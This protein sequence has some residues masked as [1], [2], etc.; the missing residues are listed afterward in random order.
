MKK[1]LLAMV[2]GMMIMS[3]VGLV[4]FTVINKNHEAELEKVK[5]EYEAEV[6]YLEE[7]YE[8]LSSEYIELNDLKSEL[9]EQVYR[10]M[11]GENYEFEI[12]YDDKRRT[13]KKTGKG[14]FRDVSHIIT[15]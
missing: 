15:W 3:C 14:L 11:E 12:K 1:N 7:E 6:N 2:I 4:G 9:E 10:M 5:A 13:Y 8:Y